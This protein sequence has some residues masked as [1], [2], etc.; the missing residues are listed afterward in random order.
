MQPQSARKLSRDLH[1]A[2]R[3]FPFEQRTSDSPLVE[4]IWRTRSVPYE[5]FISVAI[6]EQHRPMS[7]RFKTNR[8][9]AVSVCVPGRNPTQIR[10]VWLPMTYASGEVSLSR[11][12]SD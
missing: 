1:R 10:S 8:S 3:I 9:S 4:K 5:A 11:R 12:G 2:V 6:T 7:S